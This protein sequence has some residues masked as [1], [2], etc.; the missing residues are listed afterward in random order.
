MLTM[1]K[2]FEG[3]EVVWNQKNCC[4]WKYKEYNRYMQNNDES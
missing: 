2:N 1:H 4:S 3:M